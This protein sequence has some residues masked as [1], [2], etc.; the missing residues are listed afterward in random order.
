MTSCVSGVGSGPSYLPSVWQHAFELLNHFRFLI[1]SLGRNT[2]LIFLPETA[3]LVL[4]VSSD[5]FDI[6]SCIASDTDFAIDNCF[7]CAFLFGLIWVIW[8]PE[9]VVGLS[10]IADIYWMLSWDY[11]L[12]TIWVTDC[13]GIGFNLGILWE[14]MSCYDAYSN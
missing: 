2:K 10:S 9:A 12:L 13:L 5:V 3:L 14:S 8:K 11:D 6:V 1:W 7:E 4:R